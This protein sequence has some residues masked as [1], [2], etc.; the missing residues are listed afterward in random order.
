MT[1]WNDMT[2]CLSLSDLGESLDNYWELNVP[3]GIYWYINLQ[4]RGRQ[5]IG[6]ESYTL[7]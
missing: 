5:N 7:N 1:V 4:S 3:Y 2:I 6:F